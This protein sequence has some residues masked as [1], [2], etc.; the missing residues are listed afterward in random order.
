MQLMGEIYRNASTVLVW[1]G[2]RD[3]DST[4]AVES[5]RGVLAAKEES[6]DSS[7]DKVL[8][9]P[10]SGDWGLRVPDPNPESALVMSTKPPV[11]R[12]SVIIA[13]DEMAAIVKWQ[14]QSYWFRT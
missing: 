4:L 13:E 14:S 12:N 10:G 1:L 8:I 7:K 3:N 9:R 5:F 2:L 11:H 6:G